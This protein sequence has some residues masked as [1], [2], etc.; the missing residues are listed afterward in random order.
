V[1]PVL[2]T[3]TPWRALQLLLVLVAAC[4]GL[5]AGV[6]HAASD[7]ERGL[8]GRSLYAQSCAPCHGATGHGDGPEAPS[9]APPPRDLRSGIL[10]GIS[11][12]QAMARIRDGTPVTFEPRSLTARLG[13]LEE[14]TAHVRRL[15]DIDWPRVDRGATIFAERCAV[16][17]GPFG[18]PQP[19]AALPPGVQKPPRDLWDPQFQRSTS[20]ADMAAAMQHGKSAMPAIPG[21]GDPEQARQLV[22][23]IRLLSPGFATYSVYCAP[24]HGDEGRADGVLAAGKHKPGVVFD[25]AWLASKD[26]EQLRID[27]AH[28]L[29]QH[30]GG[31]P[32]FRGTLSD[33]QLR[34]IVRFLKRGD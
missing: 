23:F 11:E 8:D 5:G 34:A 26:P 25:R 29:A 14:V 16:C 1:R 18:K 24:C 28:M 19:S 32:H 4:I 21:V 33:E 7:A 15:P 30:G 31:M 27:V 12:D 10:D 13:G 20:D 3:P 17:H 2:R 9:F 6:G 22:A